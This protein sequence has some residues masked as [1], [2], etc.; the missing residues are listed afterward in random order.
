MPV[1]QLLEDFLDRFERLG[2]GR[3]EGRLVLVEGLDEAGALGPAL[4]GDEEVGAELEEGDWADLGA[5]RADWR[6]RW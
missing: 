5:V 2:I 3:Q 1:P 4:A 6:R